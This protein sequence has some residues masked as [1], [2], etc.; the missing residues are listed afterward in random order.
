MATETRALPHWNLDQYFPGL[1]SP[2]FASAIAAM[3]EGIAA[4]SG[5]VEEITTGTSADPVAD[6]DRAVGPLVG[7]LEDVSLIMTYISA[8]LAVNSRDAAA[9]RLMSEAQIALIPLR[10]ANTRL[11]AWIGEQDVEH[12]I[13]SSDLARE[14]AFQLRNTKEEAAHLMSPEEEALASELTLSGGSAFGKLHDDLTSQ[15][16]VRFEKRPGEEVEIAMSEVRNLANDPDRDVR[17]RAFEAE[18]AA[19][20]QWETAIAA[21]LNGVKGEHVTLARRRNWGSGLD[22]S[23]FQNH[24]DRTTLDAMMTAAREA[25]PDLRRYWKAKAKALGVEQLMWYD[26]TAPVGENNREWSWDEGMDFLLEQFGSF[27]EE[28]R[29]MAQQAIDEEWIDAEPRPGKGDGAFCANT[30]DGKSIVLSNF[31]PSFD[32][33]STMA[34]E[35]GHAYHNVCERERTSL[36]RMSTPMTLA[37]TASTFCETILRKAAIEKG[38]DDE[39]FAILEGALVDSGQIVVDITSRFLFEQAVFEQRADRQLTADEFCELMTDA[40][41][42]TYGDGIAE[43]GLHPY[44]WAVKGHYYSTNRAF[45]NYP[46]MFG[47]LFGLGLYAK[48]QEDPE[49]FRMNYDDLLASTGMADA[50]ELAGRFGFDIR[51]PDFWRASLDVIR[52]DVDEFVALVEKRYG[53]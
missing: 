48:Y 9:Q 2:E 20:K 14:H 12:L 17:R 16:M 53:K 32:G 36:Q 45:Y 27:S 15:I 49:T 22:Q 46:Y 31:T 11:T 3:K 51:T 19:W 52:Q 34:H 18:I 1:E 23:L 10:Q 41:K 7:L 8:H 28:M 5:I 26:I 6:H 29:A 47:L 42:Q 44:M 38:T 30:R 21:A 43:D 24:I 37:E 25:F 50:A 4:F 33:V 39:K 13:A 40:Q 35:L